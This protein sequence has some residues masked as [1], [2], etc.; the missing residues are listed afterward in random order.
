M[1]G[2]SLV[3]GVYFL[4]SPRK[5]YSLIMTLESYPLSSLVNRIIVNVQAIEPLCE[6]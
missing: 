2:Y 5:V 3:E 1:K 4:E 6:S